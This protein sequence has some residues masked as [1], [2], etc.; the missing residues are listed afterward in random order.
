MTNKR[1]IISGGGTGGHIFPAI[2][3]ADALKQ[4]WPDVDLLFVGASDRME[5]QKVPAAGYRIKG[6]W[7][8]G[9]QRRLTLKNLL[10]PLKLVVSLMQS[11]IVLLRFK[12]DFAVGTGGFASGPLLYVATQKN[13]PS[14]IQEQN[15]FPGIT[16]K[17]LAKRV[18]SICVAYQH[19]ARYFPVSKLVLTG[20]PIRKNLTVQTDST[21]S[22]LSFGFNPSAP[23]L[24][25]VGGSLGAKRINELIQD[26]ILFFKESNYQ[27]LWQCGELYHS[28]YRIYDNGSNICVADFIKDMSVAY[29]A[30][31]VIIS[32]AGALA[33]SELCLVAKPVIFIPSPNVAEDHQ[34]KNAQSLVEAE[35]ALMIKERD[36]DS[37]FEK[38][39]LNLISD[40]ERQK[41]FSA[42]MKKL[43]KTDAAERIVDEI[44]K[45]LTP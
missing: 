40:A 29:A 36:L 9:L 25:I 5:M 17:F 12:P 6:L 14:L 15:S 38:E 10:F 42:N 23:V 8:S 39:F 18:Q 11:F 19:M 35:A 3:I 41:N 7:I 26:K 30:A 1:I 13:I 16:N 32:R 28:Q 45:L 4:R 22:K 44:E 24:L 43:A 21:Q 31:D 2:A 27:I 33:V 34:T 20:N 37:E